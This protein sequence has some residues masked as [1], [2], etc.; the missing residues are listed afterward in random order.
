MLL[1]KLKTIGV[2]FLILSF[3][4]AIAYDLSGVDTTYN[5]GT[6]AVPF[7]TLTLTDNTICVGYTI[8]L[9]ASNYR[10]RAT[11]SGSAS[12]AFQMTN[13]TN[14]TY[15]LNYSVSWA[16]S[17]S[18]PS[19][20]S[21]LSGQNSSSTFPAQLLGALTCLLLPSNAT[22]RL[23]LLSANQQL[24]KQGIYTDTLTILIVAP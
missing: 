12:T 18:S 22:L 4:Q 20:V 16:G 21:L 5:F 13:T 6:I 15:K 1:T 10:I 3:K 19:F 7:P 2:F 17:A 14:N 9:E 11:S 8:L 24:A 23:Q